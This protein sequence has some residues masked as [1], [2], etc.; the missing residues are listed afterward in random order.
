MRAQ[1][2][3]QCEMYNLFGYFTLTLSRYMVQIGHHQE[4][5]LRIQG[6][7]GIS[8]AKQCPHK[9]VILERYSLTGDDQ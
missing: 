7:F 1:R 4:I 3:M 2:R 9:A 6:W 8:H 5:V